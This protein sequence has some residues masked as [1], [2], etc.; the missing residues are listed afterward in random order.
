M[1]N[2]III[3]I[4]K[5]EVFEWISTGQKT[6]EPVRGKAKHDDDAV[7]QCGGNILR[8]DIFK[9]GEGSLTDVLRLDNY[10]NIIPSAQSLEEAIT[11]LKRLYGTTEGA[12]TA[13][14]FKI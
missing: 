7:F 4:V 3:F 9:R 12:F 2:F 13:Y 5:K 8:G 6:I 14:Y 1:L 10:R 11:Y